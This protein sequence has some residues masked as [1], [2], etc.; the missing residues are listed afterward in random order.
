MPTSGQLYQEALQEQHP[1]LS[2][3]FC[4]SGSVQCA[5]KLPDDDF[6]RSGNCISYFNQLNFLN[7]HH[8]GEGFLVEAP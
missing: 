3:F 4:S 8:G 6:Y 2:G 1:P 7:F 5:L